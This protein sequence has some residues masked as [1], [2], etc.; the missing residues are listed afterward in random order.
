MQAKMCALWSTSAQ[1][2]SRLLSLQG[3]EAVATWTAIAW[4]LGA[5]TLVLLLVL[6]VVIATGKMRY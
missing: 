6:L 3:G 1:P 5:F 4:G 2:S